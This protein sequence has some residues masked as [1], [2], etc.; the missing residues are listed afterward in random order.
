MQQLYRLHYKYL[1]NNIFWLQKEKEERS[2]NIVNI[3][4]T[5]SEGTVS[6]EEAVEEV[7]EMLEKNRRKLLRMV[8]HK[9]ESS[10]LPQVCKDLFW[11]TSKVAHI[12]YSNGNEF[13]SPEG[14][15]SNINTLFYKPVDLSPKQ[16]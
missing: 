9:K 4:V 12:L 11:N 10:Q 16:A 15:K 3:L 14:L 8:L 2:S 13:R 7:K 5:Q 6:E 1:F